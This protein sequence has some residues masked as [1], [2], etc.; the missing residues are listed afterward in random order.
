MSCIPST[1]DIYIVFTLY[2]LHHDNHLVTSILRVNMSMFNSVIAENYQYL[3]YKYQISNEDWNTDVSFLLGKVKLST[4]I[5][6]NTQTVCNTIIELCE[7]RDD[8]TVCPGLD[9]D[10]VT[11]MLTHICL[12]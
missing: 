11:I 12:N 1:R 3:S 8:I 7:I 6:L 5:S 4:D 10:D 9:N 2:V